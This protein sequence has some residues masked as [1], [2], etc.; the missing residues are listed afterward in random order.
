MIERNKQLDGLKGITAIIILV[1]HLFCRYLQ[2]YENNNIEWM[3]NWGTF[4]VIVFILISGLLLGLEN[5]KNK[6]DEEF[7]LFKYLKKKILRLWGCYIISITITM[8]CIK[9][10]GLPGRECSWTDY[11]LN[12]FFI[13]GF[14]G[15]PYVD[16]AHWYLTTL[17]SI[18]VVIGIIRKLKL[19]DKVWIYCLWLLIVWILRKIGI[20]NITV[21]IG[22]S[23]LGIAM[24]G[25][26]LPKI[27]NE[28]SIQTQKY[29]WLMLAGLSTF[30]A[31][32][33]Q[34]L[35]IIVSM[36]LALILVM[37]CLN[38]K[39]WILETQIPLLL[40][41]ISYPVYLIH[42]NIGFVIIRELS[43]LGKGEYQIY[44]SI[45]ASV[46]TMILAIIIYK[47][48][49]IVTNYLKNVSKKKEKI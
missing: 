18:I 28:N 48:E 4:G 38:K 5:T 19:D 8:V 36:I 26:S 32:T 9:I 27:L 40:A 7:E 33:I 29:K 22:G 2:I 34:G 21:L 12:I 14:I 20:S 13:N 30:F 23:Y 37:L 3:S 39:L 46:G 1:F 24:L 42:Q 45:I 6:E 15:K 41:K 31:I 44:Y 43:K 11:I 47:I 49:I 10:L 25:F 17:I 16:G 35:S